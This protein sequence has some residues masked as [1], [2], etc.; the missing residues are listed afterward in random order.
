MK[1]YLLIIVL[2]FFSSFCFAKENYKGDVQLHGGV[3]FNTSLYKINNFIYDYSFEYTTVDFGLESWH[4]F[5]LFDSFDVGFAVGTD[6]MT[7]KEGKAVV[8]NAHIDCLQFLSIDCMV[9]PAVQFTPASFMSLR[10]SAGF[11]D[12]INTSIKFNESNTIYNNGSVGFYGE[13]Q[14]KFTPNSLFSPILGYRFS[15]N[16]DK[17]F[18]DIYEKEYDGEVNASSNLIYLGASVNW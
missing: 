8:G 18:T 2:A 12:V 7:A 17:K 3:D 14:A 4:F 9:G 15:K 10:A 5:T 1:K 6:V 13:V 11:S 16:F